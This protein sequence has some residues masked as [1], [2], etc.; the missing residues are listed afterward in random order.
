[1]LGHDGDEVSVNGQD[2]TLEVHQLA[3]ADFHVVTGAERVSWPVVFTT[4]RQLYVNTFRSFL[5]LLQFRQSWLYTY[6]TSSQLLKLEQYFTEYISVLLN[7]IC[8]S[9]EMFCQILLS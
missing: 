1:M 2:L 6:N 4:S 3:L 9:R 7:F 5:K 8:Y